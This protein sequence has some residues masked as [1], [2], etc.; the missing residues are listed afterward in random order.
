MAWHT[1]AQAEPLADLLAAVLG[2]AEGAALV[3]KFRG[4]LVLP[5]DRPDA[6]LALTALG[7]AQRT[8]LHAA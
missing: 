1:C 4:A 3:R 6:V 7:V 2:G 5:A 8:R